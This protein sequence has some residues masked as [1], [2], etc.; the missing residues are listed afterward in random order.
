M[1]SETRIKLPD[2]EYVSEEERVDILFDTWVA[3]TQKDQEMHMALLR[4]EDRPDEKKDMFYTD[5]FFGTAGLR[6]KMGPGTNRMNVYTI[7]R[8]TQAVS[9]YILSEYPEGGRRVVV[10]YDS[11]HKSDVFAERVSCILAANGVRVLLFPHMQPTPLLSF[12]VRYYKCSSGINITASHNP[13]DYNGYK[14]YGDNGAQ[15]TDQASAKVTEFMRDIDYFTGISTMPFEEGLSSGMIEYVG[16]EVTD[17]FFDE[18]MKCRLEPDSDAE[19]K[20]AY[21]PLNGTGKRWILGILNACGRTDID[22]VKEQEEPDG[23]FPTCPYPNPEMDP[24]MALAKKL[25]EEKNSDVMIATDP[26]SD[27]IGVFAPVNGEALR[28]NGNEVGCILF[29]YICRKRKKLGTMPARPVVVTTIV[30]SP[31]VDDIAKAY[32][33]EVRRTLTGFKYIA[34]QI[35]SLDEEGRTGDFIFGY[36]ESIGYMVGSYARDKD[37]VG[38]TMMVCDLTAEC[39]AYG[40]GLHDYLEEL[41]PK[42]R[43]HKDETLNIGFPGPDGMK[44]MSAVMQKIRETNITSIA[45]RSVDSKVDYLNDETGLPASNVLEYNIDGGKLLVR[46]SGTEPKIKI[47]LFAFED[48]RDSSLK[49]MEELKAFADGLM[50]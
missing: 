45:G 36:E 27:R 7:G 15:M 12:A 26:D 38:A 17:A 31:M 24:A 40:I 41:Y 35:T 34:G 39:K 6:G 32:G 21:T 47:Y 33:I 3:S 4:A 10:G 43:Y 11:R 19:I 16:E 1:E 49:L 37:A 50:S 22:I 13:S 29:E 5:L 28:I 46:P 23:D 14:V 20:I 2:M 48:S 8:V 30:S 42:Y 25:C 9:R 18:I 44:E